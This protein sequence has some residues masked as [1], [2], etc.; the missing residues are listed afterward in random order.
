MLGE[1]SP[2]GSRLLGTQIKGQVLL[3]LVNLPQGRL[4]LL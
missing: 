3:V 2:N 1:A 4:L